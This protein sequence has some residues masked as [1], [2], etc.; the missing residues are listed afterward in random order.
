MLID[1]DLPFL[2]QDIRERLNILKD[3]APTSF[4]PFDDI[5][6]LVFQLTMRM[7]GPVEIATNAKLQA[8]VLGLFE[9]IQKTA[10]PYQTIFPWLPSPALITRLI[11]GTRMYMTFKNIANERART[12]TR[13]DDAL[14]F[15]LDQ[16]DD[17]RQ[18]IQVSFNYL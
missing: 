11:A 8:K 6:K 16:C 9:S 7:A 1:L 14:Q 18:V 13:H 4:D 17:I 5:Y 12:G 15:C 2:I 3:K 10:T